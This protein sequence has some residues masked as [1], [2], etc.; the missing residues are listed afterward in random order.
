[1]FNFAFA[2]SERSLRLKSI[3]IV[4]V[5]VSVRSCHYS[6]ADPEFPCGGATNP[7]KSFYVLHFWKENCFLWAK[8]PPQ[9]THTLGSATV[10]IQ[11]PWN[12]KANTDVRVT[13]MEGSITHHD[14]GDCIDVFYDTMW[15][16]SLAGGTFT[17]QS[18]PP[19]PVFIVL[20]FWYHNTL[21]WEG[22]KSSID[23]LF[24]LYRVALADSR[25]PSNAS[26][27]SWSK[28]FHFDAVFDKNFTK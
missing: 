9:H 26:P 24:F 11:V 8:S 14:S 7:K 12:K 25:G 5:S 21:M 13:E 18:R 3:V 16:W 4:S 22:F 23:K 27:P 19:S 6:V 28:F 2:R 1:M 17:S 10:S 20:V 15:T